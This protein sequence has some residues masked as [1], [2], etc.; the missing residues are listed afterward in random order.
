MRLKN[1]SYLK[2]D[3]GTKIPKIFWNTT[4]NVLFVSYSQ[5]DTNAWFGSEFSKYMSGDFSYTGG[6]YYEI[7]GIYDLMSVLNITLEEEAK[8]FQKLAN[9]Y[10]SEDEDHEKMAVETFKTM[11]SIYMKENPEQFKLN[12]K[13]QLNE[14]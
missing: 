3:K 11:A 10:I 4:T 7:I 14:Q 6:L 1:R 13:Y 12:I 8:L 5:S 2:R 9:G